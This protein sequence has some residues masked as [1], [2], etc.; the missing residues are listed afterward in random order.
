ML[1]ILVGLGTNGI[2]QED[3]GTKVVKT[4]YPNGVLKTEGQYWYDKLD[5]FYREYY[6]NGKLWKDWKFSG[7]P[8]NKGGKDVLP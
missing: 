3:S 4:Y 1:T 6:P 5:G 7:C 8:G 2:C